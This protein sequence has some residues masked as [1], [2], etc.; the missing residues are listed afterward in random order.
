MQPPAPA[1]SRRKSA[2]ARRARS[3]RLPR[4]FYRATRIAA[5]LF[6]CAFA[7]AFATAQMVPDA[8]VINF[9]LPMFGD[10]GYRIWDLRGK[11]GLYVNENRVDV[12]DMH[13]LVYSK[14]V[15]NLVETEI[16]SPR[17][18]ML[19][20]E[21]RAVGDQT[22]TVL[23]DNFEVR[24]QRWSWDGDENRVVIDER[25]KVTFFEELSGIIQ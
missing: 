6:A 14:E 20:Q 10:D 5:A 21:N 12:V 22:I 19:I 13:L 15:P 23:G 3:P 24:G 11:Q 4:R 1:P 8:P 7:T 17:A 9:R 18:S 16:L 2:A 25:V